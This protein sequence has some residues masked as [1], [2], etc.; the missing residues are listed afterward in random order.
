MN[1]VGYP[2]DDAE[3]TS[4]NPSRFIQHRV[5][6]GER[7]RCLPGVEDASESGHG[8]GE[9]VAAATNKK[10]D[11]E[12]SVASQTRGDGETMRNPDESSR[13]CKDARG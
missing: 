1:H 4:G 8:G 12:R 11:R 9:R 6:V 10:S 7:A 2:A 5:R 3:R 13:G